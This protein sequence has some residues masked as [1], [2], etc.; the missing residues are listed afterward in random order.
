MQFTQNISQSMNFLRDFFDQFGKRFF[1]NNNVK[2]V[3]V[4]KLQA[5]ENEGFSRN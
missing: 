1:L 5:I 3:I 4:S 2:E